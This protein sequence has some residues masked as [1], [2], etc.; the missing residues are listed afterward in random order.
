M[1]IYYATSGNT[2]RGVD[3]ICSMLYKFALLAWNVHNRLLGSV[4]EFWRREGCS[5]KFLIDGWIYLDRPTYPFAMSHLMLMGSG[6][7]LDAGCWMQC[8]NGQ[9]NP[10]AWQRFV[11][12]AQSCDGS[13][14]NW[15][16][17]LDGESLRCCVRERQAVT[18]SRL[19]F[20]LN[21]PSFSQMRCQ[22]RL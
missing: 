7:M 4:E 1:N 8:D 2:P 13:V 12:V 19:K 18:T 21:H 5:D 10:N 20:I 11:K 6:W 9:S 14:G 3:Y 17:K 16:V 15:N 22:S